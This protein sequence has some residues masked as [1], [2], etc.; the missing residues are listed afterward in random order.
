MARCL[1]L[2]LHVD[3]ETIDI[4]WM[5][6][7]ASLVFAMQAG[8]MCLE[9]GL[10]RSKNSINVA[11]KNL[12]DFVVSFALF[13]SFG[14]ALMFG[15]TI[16]GWLG[17][18]QFFLPFAADAAWRTAFFVFQAMFCATAA[19][20]LSGAI[21]ER[22]RFSSYAVMTVIVSGLIY[23]VYGHW[24]WNGA[25]GL[26]EGGWLSKMGFVDFAGSTVV[27]SIGGWAALAALLIIGPRSGRFPEDGTVRDITGHNL[28]MSVL[29]T[30]L[31]FLG[32][33][34]FNGG[35]TLTLDATIA[36][37]IANTALAG[38]FGGI[39]ALLIG[40]VLR[41]RPEVSFMINGTLAGLVAITANC[42]MVSAPGAALIG[43]VGGLIMIGVEA[44]L[45][46]AR[47]D[48]AVGAIPVHL[49]AGAWG[50]LAVALLGD[51]EV[52]GT[53]RGRMEQLLVQTEGVVAAGIWGFGVT[54]VLLWILNRLL[55]MRVD[56]ESEYRGLNVTEHGATT[57]LV[58][59]LTAMDR[60]GQAGDLSMRVPVEPFTEVGQI[61][62]RYNGVMDL[63]QRAVDRAEAIVRD[64]QEGI[65]TFA[66]NGALVSINPGAERLFG[67]T[68]DRLLHRPVTMLFAGGP[69]S[70]TLELPLFIQK[71]GSPHGTTL[72]G[73]REDTT[74]FPV[75]VRLSQSTVNGERTFMA[76]LKDATERKRAEDALEASRRRMIKH[77]ETLTRLT[78]LQHESQGN[79]AV[80][81][82]ALCR[83]AGHTLHVARVSVWRL[84]RHEGTLRN[85]YCYD[86]TSAQNGGLDHRIALESVA[87]FVARFSHDRVMVTRNAV[88]DHRL[89]ALWPQYL[90]PHQTRAFLAA[91]LRLG[92]AIWGVMVFEHEHEPRRWYH[93]EEQ[94]AASVADFLVLAYEDQERRKAE[95]Q[96]RKMNEELEGRVATRTADLQQSNENLQ[97]AMERLERTQ[98]QLVT[99]EKM[100]ALGELVAGVAHEINTPVGV[101]VT[102]ASHLQQRTETF[103]GKYEAGSMKRS[104]LER[105]VGLAA[106]SSQMLLNNL[107][108]ASDLVQSFK[109]VAVDQSSQARRVFN[110]ERYTQELLLS[111]RPKLK[112]VPHKVV[113]QCPPDLVIES[114]PGAYGQILTNL[115]MNSLLHAFDLKDEGTITIDLSRQEDQIVLHFADNGRGIPEENLGRIFDPFFTTKR[116]KGGS[117]LGLH[118]LYNIVSAQLDGSIQCESTLG[119]GTR[120]TVS[121][122][123]EC[124]A[125]EMYEEHPDES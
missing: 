17:T 47:I 25:D 18:D 74:R 2:V 49:G 8:F 122:P 35:S 90:M 75:D 46:R 16:N 10:T 104:D 89:G 62:H 67:A 4:L 33:F 36:P 88:E 120:F 45:V 109:K 44:V 117:G 85:T 118:I 103:R 107:S 41:Q 61:A 81:L 86:V 58:D 64:L 94:F 71:A 50:T 22:M 101:A 95:D 115:I 7:A 111:L 6:I 124:V 108:R 28:P 20:I 14:Y 56:G 9:S 77:N 60:Q 102:A 32:W 92:G 99:S 48:D 12:T 65:I 55:P 87:E 119:E 13:W 73:V 24:A 93:E 69:Q 66:E 19:T 21:A 82:A 34:G 70:V 26:S 42:H 57:E 113:V 110:L 76:L 54:F 98:N 125:D 78:K 51:L 43:A 121:F 27:H 123:V 116:G 23:P 83:A 80:W 3:Q 63:L 112:K 72:Y 30:L 68:I 15:A 106:E 39:T 1:P 96:I 105:F 38:A 29:G 97:Q 5:L 40:W 11:I 37:I 84:D 91:Q 114:D 59:L 100:A 53:G 79:L 31:L 52:L